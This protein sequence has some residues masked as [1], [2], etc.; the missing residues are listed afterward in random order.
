M[1]VMSMKRYIL[2]LILLCVG[3]TFAFADSFIQ[4]RVTCAG[5]AVA[6]VVVTNGIH[7]TR[8][9]QS[10][11]YQLSWSEGSKYVYISTP[12]GYLTDRDTT[13]PRYYEELEQGKTK[14]YNFIL[15]K[16]PKGDDKH[17][18]FVQADIQVTSEKDLD[19]YNSVVTDCKQLIK[20]NADKDIFGVDCGD[21]V[22]D[23]PLLY[24]SYIKKAS[25]IDVPIYRVIGN[26]D[27]DYYGRSFETSY[28]TFEHYFGPQHYSFNKGKAHYVV[29]DNNYYIGR[30]FYY[31]GYV[32]EKTFRWM[33]EDLKYTPKG[34]LVFVIM[35]MPTRLTEKELTFKYDYNM[36]AD[37]TVNAEALHKFFKDYDTHFITGHMHYNLNICFSDS[38]MEHNVAAVCGTWWQSDICLDGTPRG[39]GVFEV[40]G[41]NVKW[42]YK[43]SG[44]SKDYQM[45]VYP[46]GASKEQPND[47]IA[48]VWNYDKKWKVEWIEN[49]KVMGEM[50]HF[51]GYDPSAEAFCSDT[52]KV[53]YDWISPTPTEHLFK[54]T[55][56]DANATIQ[57]KVTDRFGHVYIK[58]I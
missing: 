34:S 6:G 43:S 20:E 2:V 27:M 52:T 42:Y 39:Y 29:I 53:K 57:V 47:I 16:N 26:H 30:E 40:D 35:H 46:V 49:G 44:Y 54:A 48:N 9:D 11:Y 58:R 32:D 31:L 10:G 3:R 55:P 24:P 28:H 33:E 41:S 51:T 17:V 45:R 5:K 8:T 22:G 4:G 7:C 13:I 15:K 14:G 19:T 36:I 56:R 25:P 12:S 18:F 50:T 37:Q 1:N 23:S 38:M 21:I